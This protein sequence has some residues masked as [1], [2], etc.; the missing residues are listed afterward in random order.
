MR[1]RKWKRHKTHARIIYGHAPIVH[2]RSQ[3]WPKARTIRAIRT[4]H[5]APQTKT[6][7]AE[8]CRPQLVPWSELG[9]QLVD[10]L[11][12]HQM[13]DKRLQIVRTSIAVV[14]V[15]GML[16]HVDAEDRRA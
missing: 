3:L 1:R 2:V 5:T 12:V 4:T 13:I 14:D 6:A 11:P 9:E 7:A 8:C 10:I 15:I 16:P